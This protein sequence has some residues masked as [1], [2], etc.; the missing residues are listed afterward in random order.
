MDKDEILG[1]E[2]VTEDNLVCHNCLWRGNQH[3]YNVVKCA[4]YEVK[5][6]AVIGGDKNTKCES[7]TNE[8]EA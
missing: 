2:E 7:Y 3:G 8:E 5:P 1:V 4:M 6:F